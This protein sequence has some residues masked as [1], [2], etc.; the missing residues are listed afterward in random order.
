MVN[1]GMVMLS[2]TLAWPRNWFWEA[3]EA[4]NIPVSDKCFRDHV[5]FTGRTWT[6]FSAVTSS[7]ARYPR[8]FRVIVA[9]FDAK[10]I[11]HS[12]VW[13]TTAATEHVG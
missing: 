13:W 1:K 2:M 5:H 12:C 9:V 7:D 11:G 10:R 3:V 6:T 4:R 8:R